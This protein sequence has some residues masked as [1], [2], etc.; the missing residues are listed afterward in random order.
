MQYEIV[1]KNESFVTL[2]AG[3]YLGNG[4]T[5]VPTQYF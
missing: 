3:E 1:Y 5:L 4:I 2:G